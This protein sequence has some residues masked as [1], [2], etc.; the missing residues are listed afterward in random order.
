VARTTISSPPLQRQ[1]RLLNRD[2]TGAKPY[3]DQIKPFNFLN[4]AFV[5]KQERPHDEPRMVLISPYET[6]PNKWPSATWINRYSGRQYHLTQEPSDGR[7]RDGLVHPKT[8]GDILTE[9]LAHG[10]DKS[11]SPTGQPCEPETTGLLQRRPIKARSISHIGKEANQ[12]VECPV[13]S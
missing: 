5:D 6:D 9:Y 3:A 12:L 2:E 8:H 7:E 11:L 13:N 1:F 4:V 10:E